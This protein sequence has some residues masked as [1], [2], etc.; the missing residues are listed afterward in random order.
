MLAG[1]KYYNE[2]AILNELNRGKMSGILLITLPIGNNEDLTPRAKNGL[3]NSTIIYAEDTRVLREFCRHN[4]INL[5]DKTVHSFHDHSDE[6]TLNSIGEIMKQEEIALVSDAG[7][8]IISD[9]CFPLVKKALELGLNIRTLPGVSSV[10]TALEVSGLPP[11]PFH[12]HSF[13]P[14]DKGKR[15]NFFDECKSIYGT[16]IFFEGVSRVVKSIDDL[17]QV[18]PEESF[19]IARELTKTHESV[20]RFDATSWEQIK[21]ELI[22]KGEFVILFTNSNK[23]NSSS[24]KALEFATEIIEKGAHPKKLSKLLSEISGISSKE[25]YQKLIK[26]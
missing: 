2:V 5:S 4:D 12:F 10:T 24:S 14:R 18:F 16:H 7:S 25:I 8:P 26:K 9:P 1:R 3:Q 11:S 13:I 21:P 23:N 17:V 15:L 20:Y 22:L 19:C 6:K